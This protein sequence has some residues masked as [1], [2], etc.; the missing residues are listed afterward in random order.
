MLKKIAN[1][2]R[3]GVWKFIHKREFPE[4]RKLIGSKWVFKLKRDHTFRSCLVALGYHQIPGINFTENYSPM[5]SDIV[6][7][8][9]I[10][11]YLRFLWYCLQCDVETAFLEGRLTPEE[12]M[13]MKCPEGVDIPS[14][15]CIEINGG[16]YGLVQVA[17]I[18]WRRFADILTNPEIGMHQCAIDQCLFV[19]HNELGTV[20]LIIYVDDV[21]MWGDKVAIMD[22]LEKVQKHLTVTANDDNNDFLGCNI[23][24]NIPEKECYMHQKAILDRNDKKHGNRVEAI[25][26]PV[27]PGAPRKTL[28]IANEDDPEKLSDTE[29]EEY[30]SILGSLM[31]PVKFQRP[32]LS[33]NV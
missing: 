2:R 9:M 8:I 5:V 19:Q 25:C 31:Y 11:L 1:F 17:R 16:M 28:P 24:M 15:M 13:F 3:R 21:K 30:H 32:E 33:N 18:F 29:M 6:L 22:V 7:R 20:I 14:F 12:Y 4:G 23:I 10:V 26:Q 27:T